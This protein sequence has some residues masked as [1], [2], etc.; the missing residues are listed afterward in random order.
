MGRQKISM[1]SVDFFRKSIPPQSIIK[2]DLEFLLG[3]VKVEKGY[4]DR[5]N[6]VLEE[7]GLHK[8]GKFPDNNGILHY[9]KYCNC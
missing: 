7:C 1:L 5:V 2:I 6:S 9:N 4:I 8:R 3:T